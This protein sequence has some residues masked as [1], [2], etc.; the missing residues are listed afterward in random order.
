MTSGEVVV[1]ALEENQ[2]PEQAEQFSVNFQIREVAMRAFVDYSNSLAAIAAASKNGAENANKVAN[3]FNGLLVQIRPLATGVGTLSNGVI[4][5]ISEGYNAIAQIR[6]AQSMKAAVKEADPFVQKLAQLVVSDLDDM[7]RIVEAVA[8]NSEVGIKTC[9]K[10]HK[11]VGCQNIDTLG[12]NKKVY[13]DRVAE[14]ER[15][16]LELARNREP[17]KPELLEAVRDW[18]ALAVA[19]D[20]RLQAR[21]ALITET[22]RQKRTHMALLQKTADG[23]EQWAAVHLKL[24]KDLEDG[25]QPNIRNLVVATELLRGLSEKVEAL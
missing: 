14:V 23:F 5:L 12:Y 22:R 6:A 4:D 17:P 18:G 11:P 15:Q 19:V 20:A 7:S 16:L 1:A 8:E 2:M 21:N 3:A 10:P 25:T 24:W 13:T 9:L